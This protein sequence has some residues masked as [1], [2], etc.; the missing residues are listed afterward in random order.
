[1]RAIGLDKIVERKVE[2]SKE[3]KPLPEE[4]RRIQTGPTRQGLEGDE[5]TRKGS[6]KYFAN[7]IG[8]GKICYIHNKST[9]KIHKI[10]IHLRRMKRIK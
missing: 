9:R 4:S 8:T 5:E 7:S 3:E 6:E 10:V 2:V 1:V